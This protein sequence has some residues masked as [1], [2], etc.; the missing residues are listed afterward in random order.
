MKTFFISIICAVVLATIGVA[1]TGTVQR[2]HP[3]TQFS[4]SHRF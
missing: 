1:Y 4:T 2:H 3:E